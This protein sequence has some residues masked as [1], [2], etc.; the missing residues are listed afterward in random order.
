VSF[1]R[2]LAGFQLVKNF[3]AFH[4]TRRYIT[5]FK[6]V[7]HLSL[8]WALC[9]YFV[10]KYVFRA[11]SYHHLV[12]HWSWRITPCRLSATAYS[13]YSQLPTIMEAVPP[14]ATWGLA[15]PWWQGPTFM[16][17]Q[18]YRRSKQISIIKP[19]FKGSPYHKISK[20]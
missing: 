10:T 2:K 8:T 5:S 16:D 18:T 17:G 19:L 7:R 11:R 15:M 3:P 4:R 6:S 20:Y 12:Q 9:E 1:L 13:I 14:S